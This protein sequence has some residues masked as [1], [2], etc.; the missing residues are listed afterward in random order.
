M[1][2]GFVHS[3]MTIGLL[4]TALDL[5]IHA[6]RNVGVV[7]FYE[8]VWHDARKV[9]EKKKIALLHSYKYKYL[10]K[11]LVK[12][13][14][15]LHMTYVNGT[16]L[17]IKTLL[18]FKLLSKLLQKPVFYSQ[19]L[20]LLMKKKYYIL[21]TTEMSWYL[22]LVVYLIKLIIVLWRKIPSCGSCLVNLNM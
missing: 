8:Y 10:R 16:S 2:S 17:S 6:L 15:A 3:W 13:P 1:K 7:E 4:L 5:T 22:K 14:T 18:V 11:H 21:I 19:N 12:D 9:E 20:H